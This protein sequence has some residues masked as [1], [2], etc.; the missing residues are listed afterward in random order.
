MAVAQAL[1]SDMGIAKELES[2]LIFRSP[3]ETEKHHLGLY[4]KVFT[5][6]KRQNTFE[7]SNQSEIMIPAWNLCLFV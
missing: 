1:G 5:S 2:M 6:S 4:L 7:Q 3:S